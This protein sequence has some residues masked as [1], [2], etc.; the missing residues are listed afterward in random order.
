MNS[1]P[2]L[3]TSKSAFAHRVCDRD[4][5]NTGGVR[6]QGEWLLLDLPTPEGSRC[7]LPSTS[8]LQGGMAAV[9]DIRCR[10]RSRLSMVL[11][12]RMPCITPLPLDLGPRRPLRVRALIVVRGLCSAITG[13]EEGA[14]SRPGTRPTKRLY[15]CR[16]LR[17]R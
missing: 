13:V 4:W 14:A 1:C 17:S 15:S 11:L 16:G 5:T 2:L 7:G 8:C 3:C 12:L 10:Y 6:S 9:E